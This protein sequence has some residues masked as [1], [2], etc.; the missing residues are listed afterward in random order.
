MS[1]SRL[2]VGLAE[3]TKLTVGVKSVSGRICSES[4]DG[5]SPAG[6]SPGVSPG[7]RSVSGRSLTVRD[8]MC[9]VFS[10]TILTDVAVKSL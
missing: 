8:R 10:H 1:V 6:L 4:R 7:L 5:L 3:F 9:Y 2:P